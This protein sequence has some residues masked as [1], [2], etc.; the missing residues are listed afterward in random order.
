M[1][2][3]DS[4]ISC[5]HG[6][7]WISF[8]VVV[9]KSVFFRDFKVAERK[10]NLLFNCENNAIL[11]FCFTQIKASIYNSQISQYK[12]TFILC[13]REKLCVSAMFKSQQEKN[14]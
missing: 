2:F 11:P 6:E 12:N 10:K 8:V 4:L 1:I 3:L 5:L 13:V 14:L 9:F 7:F